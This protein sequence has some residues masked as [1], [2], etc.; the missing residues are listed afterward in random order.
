MKQNSKQYSFEEYSRSPQITVSTNTTDIDHTISTEPF[1]HKKLD[2]NILFIRS[3][4]NHAPMIYNNAVDLNTNNRAFGNFQSPR[5][6]TIS[7]IGSMTRKESSESQVKFQ[8]KYN[9]NMEIRPPSRPIDTRIN[10]KGHNSEMKDTISTRSDINIPSNV[11][12]AQ[13]L[14]NQNR[15]FG[16]VNNMLS[17]PPEYRKNEHSSKETRSSFLDNEKMYNFQAV[18]VLVD[19]EF[20]YNE[21]K[22]RAYNEKWA[23]PSKHIYTT[24]NVDDM[25]KSCR[26]SLPDDDTLTKRIFENAPKIDEIEHLKN[27]KNIK[28]FPLNVDSRANLT[29][30]TKSYTKNKSTDHYQFESVPFHDKR[31]V[32]LPESFLL[33]TETSRKSQNTKGDKDDNGEYVLRNI[34]SKPPTKPVSKIFPIGINT[35]LNS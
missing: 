21:A 27:A 35:T 8:F 5:M 2:N 1:R 10:S 33:K 31:N 22:I 18:N 29:R 6:G 23:I 3:M 28:V 26:Q 19:D 15:F 14:T 30:E 11:V 25:G 4:E 7:D 32:L 9:G 20:R 13:N 17:P 16:N 34:G 12:S 24:V